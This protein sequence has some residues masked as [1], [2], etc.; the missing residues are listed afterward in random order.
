MKVYITF[1]SVTTKEIFE[2]CNYIYDFGLIRN[3]KFWMKTIAC[4][5][6]H[7][8]SL[9]ARKP[10]IYGTCSRTTLNSSWTTSKVSAL[11]TTT[12]AHAVDG[13]SFK[14]LMSVPP[15]YF[16]LHL[17]CSSEP[18]PTE[19][20]LQA[21]SSSRICLLLSMSCVLYGQ[22]TSKRY[23]STPPGRLKR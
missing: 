6:M 8:T 2:R 13:S 15:I 23:E 14:K 7:N 20:K 1:L 10:G 17:S 22:T 12:A 11:R 4:P 3:R 18:E 9:N 5:K 21:N 16:S 19:G